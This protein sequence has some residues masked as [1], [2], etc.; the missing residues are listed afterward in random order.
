MQLPNGVQSPQAPVFEARDIVVRF[1]GLTALDEVTI[2]VPPASLIGL[3][4]PNGAGKSTF[5]SVCTGLLRADEGRQFLSGFDITTWKPQERT[6]HGLALTFQHPDL[7]MGLTVS[8][9]LRLAYRSRHHRRRL[10]LDMFTGGSLRGGGSAEEERIDKIL[11]QVSLREFASTV[12]DVLPLGTRKLVEVGRAL[13]TTPTVLLLDEPLA[14]LDHVEATE[15]GRA[16][17]DIVANESIALILVE[18]DVSMVLSLCSYLYVL[19]FGKLLA[20]G[21]PEEMRSNVAVRAAY[22]GDEEIGE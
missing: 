22:L 19:D 12:V 17:K 14:G 7:F 8:D 1:G 2:S 9:H 18:H 20:E 13:A 21:T 16:L 5:F 6:R 11:D 4:G 3:V 10:W 15:L